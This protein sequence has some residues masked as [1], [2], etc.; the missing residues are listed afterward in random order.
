MEDME[1]IEEQAL[2]ITEVRPV[3]INWLA[4][5]ELSAITRR[6]ADGSYVVQKNGLPYHVPNSEEFADFFSQL[7]EYARAHSEAV[8]EERPH[9]PSAGEVKT[10]ALARID[11]ATSKAILAGFEYEVE[12][13]EGKEVLHFS[14]QHDDQQNFSD[15][16]N[17]ALLAM[18][19]VESV[20]TSVKWNGWR[21]HNAKSKGEL[22]RLVLDV[23]TF[24]ALYT[25]GALV[26]KAVQ[27]EIGGQRK[28]A[29][30]AAETVEEINALLEG[31]GV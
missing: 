21:N 1:K 24:L 7:D 16:A 14:Y 31:W 30:E 20:P 27:M 22:V 11:A 19:G 3:E 15:T 25:G 4:D 9:V 28:A 12:T 5:V 2:D 29:V 17:G 23:Q 10:A 26:H 13:G 8:T 6:V 18:Q